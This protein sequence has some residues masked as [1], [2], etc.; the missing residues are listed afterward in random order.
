MNTDDRL[1]AI[2][3]AT[4]TGM[5]LMTSPAAQETFAEIYR[6]VIALRSH[7]EAM[8]LLDTTKQR[9]ESF[10]KAGY[11][12]NEVMWKAWNQAWDAAIDALLGGAK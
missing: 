11:W 2:E 4:K 12:P 1:E 5:R 8:R 6:H 9:R 7:A 10:D 3:L